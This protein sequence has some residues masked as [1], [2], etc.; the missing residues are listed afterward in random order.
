MRFTLTGR[1]PGLEGQRSVT[2]ADGKLEGDDAATVCAA[3]RI[4]AYD[5]EYVG[6]PE[7]PLTKR[8]H[9]SSGLSTFVILRDFFEPGAQLSGTVPSRPEIPVDAIG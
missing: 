2:W 6:P 4:K 1:I 9:V 8:N 3:L 5:G 7:G